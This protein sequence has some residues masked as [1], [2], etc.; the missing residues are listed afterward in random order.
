MT[1][2]LSYQQQMPANYSG[3]TIQI[4]NPTVNATPQGAYCTAPQMQQ[5]PALQIQ[6]PRNEVPICYNNYENAEAIKPAVLDKAIQEA[7]NIADKERIAPTETMQSPENIPTAQGDNI[8][9]SYPP[10]YYMNN[11]NYVQNPQEKTFDKSIAESQPATTDINQQKADKT[12]IQ[13]EDMSKSKEIIDNIDS[14]N[15]EE[16]KLEKEGKKTKVVTL[17][18]EY[19]MSLENY[20]NNPNPEIRIMA[21]KEIL[22]RL[23]EDKSRYDDAALNALLNKMLQDPEKLVRIAAMSALSSQLASGNDYTVKLLEQIQQNPNSDKEDV[24]EAA[25]ILLKRSAKTEIQYSPNETK[26][27]QK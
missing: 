6:P 5:M 21:S 17:T 9:N 4:T 24:L 3:V 18:N 7:E 12:D 2:P 15:A 23:D 27:E 22:T 14:R 1:N 16:K 8:Q 13:E 25:E 19:I 26:G 10:Q 20:L 11:Y